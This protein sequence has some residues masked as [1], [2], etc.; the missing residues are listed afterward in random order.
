MTETF[1]ITVTSVNDQ[2]PAIMSTAPSVK[3]VVGERV[4]IGPEDLQVFEEHA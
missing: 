4:T 3:V 1:N 2:P